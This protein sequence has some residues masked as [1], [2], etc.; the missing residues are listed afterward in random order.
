MFKLI[1][2]GCLF[3]GVS[4]FRLEAAEPSRPER[5]NILLIT[6]DDLGFQLG[7]YGD[8][9]VTTP[10]IDRLAGRGMRFTNAY[11]ASGSCSPSRSSI[12]TGLY[13]HQN[14]QVGLSQLG[15]AMKPGLP[16]MVS[17]LRQQG[18]LTGIIGKLHV[19]PVDDFPFDFANLSHEVSRQPEKV[20]ELCDVFF[21]ETK[22]DPFF[23]YLN[24]F[25][26]HAPFE[27]DIA[28]SPKVKVTEEQAGLLSFIGQDTPV[29][30]EQVA[31]FMTCVNRLDEIMGVVLASLK[32]HGLDENT[33]IIFISDNGPPFP[34]A[35]VTCYE[36]GV[37]V[38]LIITWP[39]HFKTGVNAE[40]V[41]AI[42]L[43][44]TVLELAGAPAVPGLPGE[45]LLPLL[46]GRPVEWR[47]QV[48][49]E[50]NTH[51]PR[52]LNPRRA[53][54]EGRYKLIMTLLADP[55]M[56]WP[57]SLT[58]EKFRTIQKEAGQGEFL[59]LYDLENDPDEFKNLA[60]TPELAEVQASLV[61]SLQDWRRDTEDPLLDPAQMQSFLQDGM[62][63]VDTPTMISLLLDKQRRASA[64]WKNVN[65]PNAI[66]PEEM[67]KLRQR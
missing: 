48:F 24:L 12:L 50:Y 19:E 5:A 20:R 54:R 2:T 45:S 40:L 33:S 16:N 60:G 39:G 1:I 37:R 58:L 64:G 49:T 22:D 34:R 36:A 53:V 32:E 65:N 59:E 44:P 35:K 43:L 41:N 66:S 52:M 23:L 21:G 17:L 63:A 26:P 13:P 7:C 4:F 14:G 8:R 51:E 15:Y 11:V 46:E 67:E 27:R 56:V 57:E 6:A 29:L 31:G 9:V 62:Q 28:G 47:Q 10:N 18:Y 61:R 3:L 42:D 38:P 55:D 30:R 25:D